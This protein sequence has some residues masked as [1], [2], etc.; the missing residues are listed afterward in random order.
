[1]STYFYTTVPSHKKTAGLYHF[2][3]ICLTFP[4][5][6]LASLQMLD[7]IRTIRTVQT[8]AGIPVSLTKYEP[9]VQSWIW[10]ER[11][12]R[13]LR[14]WPSR[15]W[16]ILRRLRR[17]HLSSKRQFLTL[18]INKHQKA[19]SRFWSIFRRRGDY[20]KAQNNCV[21]VCLYLSEKVKAWLREEETPV[22]YQIWDTSPRV[23]I[24]GLI[25]G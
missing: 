18:V 17:N 23:S 3:R 9:G 20:L 4:W 21:I 22:L 10:E 8:N 7:K 6:M 5:T 13:V 16:S 1:M 25:E 19:Q 2:L 14:D 12:M 11:S 24:K 15:F